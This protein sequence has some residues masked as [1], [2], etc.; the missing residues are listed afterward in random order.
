MIIVFS[1]MAMAHS[2]YK[3]SYEPRLADPIITPQL[4]I[5][6]SLYARQAVIRAFA[7]LS[8]LSAPSVGSCIDIDVLSKAV[9]ELDRHIETINLKDSG[10]ALRFI[11]S[12]AASR[13]S[14][15]VVITG[16]PRLCQRSIAPLV[17]ALRRLGADIEYLDVEGFAPIRVKGGQ[18]TGG[19]ELHVDASISSQ[20]TSALLML[21]PM[22]DGGLKLLLNGSVSKPYVDMT[23]R[24]MKHYGAEIHNS[25]ESITALQSAYQDASPLIEPDCSALTYFHQFCYLT[26]RQLNLPTYSSIQPDSIAAALFASAHNCE[27]FERDMSATPDLVPALAVALALSGKHFKITGIEHLRVKESDRIEALSCGLQS[28]GFKVS[29]ATG[30][31]A[32]HGM[33]MP[34]DE[35][36][37]IDSFGDHRIAMAFAIAAINHP[38]IIVNPEVVEK[39]F[40]LFWHE[41]AKLGFNIQKI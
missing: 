1:P 7:G 35:V 29:Q 5:C 17:D 32:W 8:P 18:L 40:P 2:C 25:G 33:K 23:C 4:P 13:R 10:T 9:D 11:T 20:F 19:L 31:L 26:H 27:P 37:A 36:P 22:L 21:A 24:V 39:S 16:S 6:K 38:L 14:T 28:L 30:E 3:I 12:L 34:H 15:S 41:L